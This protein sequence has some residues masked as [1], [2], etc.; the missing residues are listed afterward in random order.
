MQRLFW[1][2]QNAGAEE[3]RR[4]GR[5]MIGSHQYQNSS[6]EI[7]SPTESEITLAPVR[8]SNPH[9]ISAPS[10]PTNTPVAVC[11]TKTMTR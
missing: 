10:A 2:Y 7:F 11:A 3:A 9:Q 8:S 5:L 4:V 6:P 1:R